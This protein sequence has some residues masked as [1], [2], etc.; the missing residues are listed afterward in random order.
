MEDIPHPRVT[1]RH[2]FATHRIA[3]ATFYSKIHSRTRISRI[4]ARINL[5]YAAVLL[6]N[7]KER[8][9]PLPL[10][11]PCLYRGGIA[12]ARSRPRNFARCNLAAP[13]QFIRAYAAAYKLNHYRALEI[14]RYGRTA[15]NNITHTRN[16]RNLRA[17]TRAHDW[18]NASE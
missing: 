16:A 14:S 11:P 10:L 5:H 1:H 7:E 15:G 18:R 6:Y 12:R 2:I 17:S 3:S 8:P 4:I 9:L 13:Q